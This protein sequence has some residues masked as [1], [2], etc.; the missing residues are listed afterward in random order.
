MWAKVP[1]TLVAVLAIGTQSEAVAS[2]RR[3]ILLTNFACV[4][5]IASTILFDGLYAAADVRILWPVI[6][7]LSVFLPAF[8]GAIAANRFGYHA[9]AKLALCGGQSSLMWVCTGVFLGRE[10]GM[11]FYFLLFAMVPFLCWSLR[12]PWPIAF[13]FLLDFACFLYVEYLLP[14]H[15]VFIPAFPLDHVR[16]FQLLSLLGIFSSVVLT[17]ALSLHQAAT[18][19]DRLA[20]QAAELADANQR[21]QKALGEV[22]TLRGI[23]PICSYCNRIRDEG[24]R[25]QPVDRYVHEHS[26]A[27]FSH[28]ICPECMKEHY[29]DY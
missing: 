1:G 2:E 17:V 14:Q 22:K 25:W 23:L 7:G 18:S 13:F 9:A 8:I 15:A 28:G 6:A 20:H 10:T 3:H 11:H 27:K 4:V 26:D 5:S 12:H 29:P 24:D 21:L 16:T 19:E